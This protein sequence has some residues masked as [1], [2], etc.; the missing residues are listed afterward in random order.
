MVVEPLFIT[1]FWLALTGCIYSYAL[2]PLILQF[3]ME[4]PKA[5]DLDGALQNW[6]GISHIITVHNEAGRIR[7]KLENALAMAYPGD[8]EILV[9]SDGSTDATNTIVAEY[10][11]KGVRLIDVKDHKGKEN[12]QLQGIRRAQGEILVFS[13]VATRMEEQAF[14]QVVR[15]FSD[16]QVGAAS[17]EDR[18]ISQD[19]AIVGEG[20]YVKYEMWLR[21]CESRAAGLVGLSGSFFAA[22]KTVCE[23]WDIYSP[24]DFNTALNCARQGLKAVT[25]PDVY[26]YYKDLA[27]AS[28][29]YQRKIRTLIRGFT[30]ISRHRDVLNVKKFGLFAFQVWSH[31]IMRWAV[32]WFMLLL[33][34]LSVLLSGTTEIYTLI[35]YLQVVFYACVIFAA[36]F[37]ALRSLL[38]FRLP[39]FFVQVNLAIAHA[40]LLFATGKRMTTW[41]PS[42]R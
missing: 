13:D 25:M 5:S 14:C 39:L 33:L 42:Q 15:Y 20:A 32:P 41:T 23:E 7:Q 36:V 3:F 37:L 22:R 8:M 21:R 38:V 9:A 6:P 27:D 11:D 26:G 2:Y 28:K 1:L 4:K 31:K 17:S 19:G 10:A 35:L 18:F 24:S 29:E 16:P 34:C 30:A 12:A 40:C